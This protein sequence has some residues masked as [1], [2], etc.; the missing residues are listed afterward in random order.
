MVQ[1]NSIYNKNMEAVNDMGCQLVPIGP[2]GTVA[3]RYSTVSRVR[4]A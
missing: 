1:H 3:V 4:L 2:A